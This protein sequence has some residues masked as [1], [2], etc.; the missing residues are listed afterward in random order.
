VKRLHH[1]Q[2]LVGRLVVVVLIDLA[3]GEI[4]EFLGV[5]LALQVEV[6]R[7]V[8]GLLKIARFLRAVHV[9]HVVRQRDAL[10]EGTRVPPALLLHQ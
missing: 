2:V 3:D 4:G 10:E 8:L 9:L 5:R 7:V 6:D 1:Q